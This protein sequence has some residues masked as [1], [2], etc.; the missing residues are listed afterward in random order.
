MD[1]KFS[2]NLVNVLDEIKFILSENKERTE[3]DEL[4]VEQII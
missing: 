2:K 1:D 3:A 4:F